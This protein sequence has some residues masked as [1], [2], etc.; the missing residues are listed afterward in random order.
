LVYPVVFPPLA[1]IPLLA[2]VARRAEVTAALHLI[3]LPLL[4]SP[5]G[6]ILAPYAADL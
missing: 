1:P 6:F 5:W 4:P 2:F 3:A